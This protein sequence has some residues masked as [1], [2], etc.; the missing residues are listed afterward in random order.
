[1]TRE[2]MLLDLQQL[3]F[4][5]HALISVSGLSLRA[6]LLGTARLCTALELLSAAK[7]HGAGC[8]CEQFV[9]TPKRFWNK[10]P[11]KMLSYCK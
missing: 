7:P 8:L 6:S 9:K 3:N 2:P 5:H 11:Y 10:R 4:A 1:M